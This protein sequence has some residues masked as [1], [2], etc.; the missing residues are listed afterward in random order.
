MVAAISSCGHTFARFAFETKCPG[1]QACGGCRGVLFCHKKVRW[2][3][4][5]PQMGPRWAPDGPQ[6]KTACFSVSQ[7]FSA[8]S[9]ENARCATP[10]WTRFERNRLHFLGFRPFSRCFR[11][12]IVTCQ[13][14]VTIFPSQTG[15]RVVV[16][17]RVESCRWPVSGGEVL[18]SSTLR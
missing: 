18:V 10:F 17:V 8:K 2:A 6:M 14:H 11:E 13:W 5:G 3:P 4:D 7:A 15:W 12:S 16:Q 9:A 1:N